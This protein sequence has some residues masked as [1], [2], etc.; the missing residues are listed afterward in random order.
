M[1]GLLALENL[2]L[3]EVVVI[4]A[5]T[6]FTKGSRIYLLEGE[7]VTVEQLLNAM[8]I[9]SAND[10]AV[11]LAKA[12]SGTVE[13]FA[14]L[15]NWRAKE[16][17]GQDTNFVNP[18][19]LENDEHVTSAH[20]LAM[21][22][23]EAMKNET[24]RQVV[25]TYQY[26]LPQTNM[27]DT[28]YFYNGNRLIYDEKHTV[29]YEGET[30]PAKYEGATGIKTGHT[31][32]AGRCLVAGAQRDGT[33][34]I[35]VMMEGDGENIYLDAISLLEYGFANYQTAQAVAGGA[36][37]GELS[38]R[39]G[40]VKSVELSAAKDM[41]VTI[42]SDVSPSLLELKA[43]VPD[44]MKAPVEAGSTVGVLSVVLDGAVLGAVDILADGTVEKG[45][46]LSYVGIP[47]K[48]AGVIRNGAFA[49]LGLLVLLLAA[50]I[51]LKRRQIRR[52]KRRRAERAARVAQSIER[53][54]R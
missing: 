17:G 37:Q 23:M 28:R 48:T 15:M 42:P 26:T 13:D 30:R 27:Q 16:L 51:V 34:L 41:W 5:E 47:D 19:G 45:G 25:S 46:P 24:F 4:D 20:D 54:R 35:A 1:T 7:Q 43:E 18:N 22:A 8:L 14:Q 44:S 3:D 50:Y 38:V 52:R 40:A 12:V 32:Q 6:P 29:V 33:E 2:K 36:P 11:A 39:N 53:A 31:P 10:A 49:V 21:F 9:E